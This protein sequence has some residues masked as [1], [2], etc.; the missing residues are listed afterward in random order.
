MKERIEIDEVRERMPARDDAEV[1][2]VQEAQRRAEKPR[3]REDL[4]RRQGNRNLLQPRVEWA[5]SPFHL[6]EKCVQGRQPPPA[7]FVES[8][9]EFAVRSAKGDPM[10]GKK[11]NIS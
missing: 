6:V 4:G 9:R 7:D 10:S 8:S 2:F 3:N 11:F 1:H 5:V